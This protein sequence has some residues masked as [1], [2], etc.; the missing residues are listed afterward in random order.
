M[1]LGNTGAVQR[2]KLKQW[3]RFRRVRHRLRTFQ[4]SPI[5]L[6]TV[7]GFLLALNTEMRSFE[8]SVTALLLKAVAAENK[9]PKSSEELTFDSENRQ[10]LKN[11]KKRLEEQIPRNL[12]QPKR[13]AAVLH[14]IFMIHTL[15][16]RSGSFRQIPTQDG[17]H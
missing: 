5:N 7:L 6:V 8:F 11:C 15:L 16:H 3:K 4:S 17:N 14:A 9:L 2:R 1:K 13:L 10:L 12:T